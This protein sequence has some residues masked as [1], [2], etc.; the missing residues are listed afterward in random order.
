MS[1]RHEVAL[2]FFFLKMCEVLTN[3]F[4]HK[5]NVQLQVI[6]TYTRPAYIINF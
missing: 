4:E 3:C 1:Y 6:K 5:V 2:R